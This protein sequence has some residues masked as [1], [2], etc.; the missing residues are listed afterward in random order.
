M[1]NYDLFCNRLVI[2]IYLVGN[3]DHIA[4]TSGDDKL[5]YLITHAGVL[6]AYSKAPCGPVGTTPKNIPPDVMIVQSRNLSMFD[7]SIM[8]VAEMPAHTVEI[9]VCE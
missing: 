8:S 1:I 6:L 9:N 3:Y 7:A 4:C 2:Q 5:R